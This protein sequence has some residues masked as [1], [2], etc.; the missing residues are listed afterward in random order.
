MTVLRR[1]GQLSR[2]AA[3]PL[4]VSGAAALV[5]ACAPGPPLATPT[6][7]VP[8][9]PTTGLSTNVASAT[10]APPV[11]STP[12]PAAASTLPPKSGGA[13]RV[14]QVGDIVT[15]DPQFYAFGTTEN[16][17][18]LYDRLTAYD[19]QRKPQP[20]LAE[21]WDLSSDA[22]QIK[23][24]LRKGVQFHSGREFS[25]DDVKNTLTRIRDPKVGIGQF[26][27]QGQWFSQI[28]TP[29]KYT[30]ILSSD[31]PRPAIF[32]LF[33][34]LN[35]GDQATLEGPDARTKANGT[36]PFKLQEWAQGDHVSFAK[37]QNYWQTG[38]PYLS[39]MQTSVLRDSQSM[40]TQLEA[41]ALDV[42]RLPPRQDFVRLRANAQFQ[43]IS[44]PVTDSVAFGLGLNVQHPPL[45]NKLVRQAL[46]YALDRKRFVD[47]LLL[48]LGTTQDLPWNE[49]S[50]MYEASKMQLYTFDLDK[51]RA[52]LDQAGVS[53][54]TINISPSPAT[55]E[56]V[57]FC[58]IYQQDLSKI[59]I[60][61]NIINL[62]TA[63]WTAQVN[64][65]G[66]EGLYSATSSNLHLSPGWLFNTSR[67][68]NPNDNNEGFKSDT[69][70]NL[71]QQVNTEVDPARLKQ[72]Y[73]QLNDVIL[74][75]SFVM[76]MSPYLLL[77][78][79]RAGVHDVVPNLH[80]GW[81]YTDAWLD[82]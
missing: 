41:G 37:N 63:A 38:R 7:S 65:R 76:Y 11:A 81:A 19:L 24:N 78:L 69:F 36:G 40:V 27:Q 25:S 17:F 43:A 26:A 74:D 61:L 75:E 5:A 28:E 57:T 35:I 72:L 66:Y 59:G 70:T 4:I 20:Q 13:L 80:G 1:T 15:L 14:G 30:A 52:L 34:Y 39:T 31:T 10:V 44:H 56:G 18:L 12:A 58:Q 42:I 64:S 8:T 60:T 68:L 67:P 54:A 22:R 9:A 51:A 29:D 62:E 16:T 6:A 77:M 71:V 46:N 48:G 47:A 50:A 79:A 45:D 55:P 73:A 21:S 49:A 2:R 53:S 3:L 23:L 33:E 82:S 32:D